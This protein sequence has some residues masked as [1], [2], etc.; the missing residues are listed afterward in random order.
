MILP[1]ANRRD[2]WTQILW[3]IADFT[4]RFG[5]APEGLWLAETAVDLET[6]DIMAERGLTFTILAPS[7]AGRMR[8]DGRGGVG[9]C[10][11]GAH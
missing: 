9:R 5:R 10:L 6:L 2:K 1:L 4:H 11:R 8:A 7:Q 3:G